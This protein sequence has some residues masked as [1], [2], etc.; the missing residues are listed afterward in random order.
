MATDCVL[1]DQAEPGAAVTYRMTRAMAAKDRPADGVMAGLAELAQAAGLGQRELLAR[2][3]QF[4]RGTGQKQL[5]F[6]VLRIQVIGAPA[7]GQDQQALWRKFLMIS[8]ELLGRAGAAAAGGLPQEAG[9]RQPRPRR[10]DGGRGQLADRDRLVRCAAP[11][12]RP[13]AGRCGRGCARRAVAAGGPGAG[14]GL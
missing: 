5:E 9:V 3:T 12:Q 14:P 6:K 2:T 13:G 10:A 1:I 8:H 7:P 11:G 4:C